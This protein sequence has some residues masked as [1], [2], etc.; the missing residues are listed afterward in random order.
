MMQQG[1]RRAMH[2][3]PRR[4]DTLARHIVVASAAPRAVRPIHSCIHPTAVR[5][6]D[7]AVTAHPPLPCTPSTVYRPP[8]AADIARYNDEGF[9]VVQNV[10]SKAEVQL[11]TA[12]RGAPRRRPAR[13][14]AGAP[15][16]LAV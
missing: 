9:L 1:T 14:F 10:L 11:V 7:A 5:G 3:V 16:K 15:G 4:L 8:T 2:A 6:R 12:V 13:N